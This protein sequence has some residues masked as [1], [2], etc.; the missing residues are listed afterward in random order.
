M[1]F[2]EDTVRCGGVSLMRIVLASVFFVVAWSPGYAGDVEF[3][4]EL[5]GFWVDD[6]ATCDVLKRASPAELRDG[7]RWLKIAATDILGTTQ[8]RLLREIPPQTGFGRPIKKAFEFEMVDIFWP[9]AQ[10]SFPEQ[11]LYETITGG[12]RP[13]YY[14]KCF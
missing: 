13:R 10:L 1:A 9:I 7:Q 6:Q 5:R 11:G 8:G 12:R 14:F 2:K 4:P 3:P